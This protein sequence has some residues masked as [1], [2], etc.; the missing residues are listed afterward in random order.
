VGTDGHR[1]LGL[2]TMTERAQAMNG[3]CR[4]DASPGHGT[5]VTVEVPR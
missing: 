4:I 2:L 5:R 3:V 1:H